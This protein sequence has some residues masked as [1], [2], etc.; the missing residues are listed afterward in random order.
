MRFSSSKLLVALFCSGLMIAGSAVAQERP[1][2]PEAPEPTKPERPQPKLGQ[3]QKQADID[4]SGK[5][6]KQFADIYA[7]ASK[8]RSK[9][10]GQAQNAENREEAMKLRKQMNGEM[11]QVIQDSP[12]SMQRYRQIAQAASS[13]PELK[14]KLKQAIQQ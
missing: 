13:D 12:L 10:A 8:I 11:M 14:K 4:V 3:Q 9:Y 2:A 6:V 5:E 1:D 7:E